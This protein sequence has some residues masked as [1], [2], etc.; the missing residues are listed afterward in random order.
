[1]KL[2]ASPIGDDATGM[3]QIQSPLANLTIQLHD[4]RKKMKHKNIFGARSAEHM[5]TLR[6]TI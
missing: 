3:V 5:G 1:M 6:I 2:K 4:I